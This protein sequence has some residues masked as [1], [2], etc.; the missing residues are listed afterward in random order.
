MGL[1]LSAAVLD[2]LEVRVGRL[3]EDVAQLLGG[4]NLILGGEP[5]DSSPLLPAPTEKRASRLAGVVGDCGEPERAKVV[6][7]EGED[8]FDIA[9]VGEYTGRVIDE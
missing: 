3:S 4:E 5:R 8:V 9:L 6:R 2:L 1:E 7:I